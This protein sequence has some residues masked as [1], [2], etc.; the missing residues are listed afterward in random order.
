MKKAP[1]AK[2]MG[3]KAL[4]KSLYRGKDEARID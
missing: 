4:R 2:I 1:A 3:I